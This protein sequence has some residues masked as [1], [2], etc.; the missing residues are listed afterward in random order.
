MP[1]ANRHFL[2]GYIWHITHRC[3]QK[4]FLLKF[5]RDRRCYLR[6]VFE[7]K[8]RFGLSVLNYVVTSNHIHLLV[9]GTGRNVTA[10]SMQLIAGRTAQEYNQRK[11]RHGAFWEDRYHA[12]AI[13]VD[14]HLHRCLVYIDLNMVRAGVVNHP[15]QWA[16][17][18]CREIQEPPERYAVIDLRGLIALCGFTDVADFQRAHRKWVEEALTSEMAV[19]DDR[20]SK[21]IAVGSLAF[22]DKL[23]SE[24]G[25]KAMHRE[26]VQL[27][28][29][30]TLREES[31]AY[32]GDFTSENDALTPDNTIPWEENIES[33]D[34]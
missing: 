8:K 19:R 29:T 34:T 21:A 14:E 4:K 28:G 20:W 7:A 6:W 1:R 33:I 2:P 12:T 16:H 18:G 10:Q 30:Y 26:V 17:S 9:K 15:A 24:L 13:E 3:H 5:A 27:N 11:R 23:R 22:V 25:V 32:G 31:E